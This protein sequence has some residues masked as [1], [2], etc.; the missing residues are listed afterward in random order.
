MNKSDF[1]AMF[2]GLDDDLVKVIARVMVE[3]SPKNQNDYMKR[4]LVMNPQQIDAINAK[5]WK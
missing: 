4:L 5:S 2:E 3:P 1:L